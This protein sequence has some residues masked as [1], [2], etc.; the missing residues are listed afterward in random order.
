MDAKNFIGPL[1]DRIKKSLYD[2]EMMLE[3]VNSYFSCDFLQMKGFILEY[4]E[5]K[6]FIDLVKYFAAVYWNNPANKYAT[7]AG[8]VIAFFKFPEGPDQSNVTIAEFFKSHN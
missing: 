6:F 7:L 4:G 3:A 2:S 8:M 1:S 5:E